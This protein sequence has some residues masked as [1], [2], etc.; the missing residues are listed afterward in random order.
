MFLESF[1]LGCELLRQSRLATTSAPLRGFVFF[2]SVR[3]SGAVCPA[4][5]TSSGGQGFTTELGSIACV[6][7]EAHSL[8]GLD[9]RSQ[10]LAGEAVR[11]R[12]AG[13]ILMGGGNLG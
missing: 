6:G 4:W 10:P 12:S 5:P 3:P 9:D 8:G 13:Q 1:R 7:E 2:R 11:E